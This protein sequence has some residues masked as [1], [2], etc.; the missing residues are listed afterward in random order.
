MVKCN[1]VSLVA[2]NAQL[3]TTVHQKNRSFPPELELKC[4]L[5][6][7]YFNLSRQTVYCGS[8]TSSQH[9]VRDAACTKRSLCILYIF[10]VVLA[11]IMHNKLIYRVSHKVL[12]V[13]C[14]Y[15]GDYY[16]HPVK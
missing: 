6:M 13:I 4:V 1:F 15:L 3:E 10:P 8:M 7:R 16:T 14:K 12:K 11:V 2:R 9:V 5:I